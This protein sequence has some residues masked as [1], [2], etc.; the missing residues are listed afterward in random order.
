MTPISTRLCVTI[1]TLTVGACA[2]AQRVPDEVRSVRPFRTYAVGL[3]L[4][5]GG[6]GGELATPL[7]QHL[8][9][10]G[11]GQ[12]FHYSTS[13]TTNGLNATGQLELNN[14]YVAIGY[15]P[16]H[17][18]FHITPGVTFHNRNNVSAVLNE[19]AGSTFT[20]N[21]VDY[22]SQAND[23]IKGNASIVFGKMVAPRLTLG[24][25]NMFPSGGRRFSFP[26]EV[27]AEYA[28]AP[29]VT[30][31]FS[32]SACTNQGCGS[33]NTP[34]NRANIAGEQNKL[35]AD[36]LPLRFYPIVSFGITYRL[37]R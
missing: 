28:S 18:G 34:E 16:F 31:A 26:V 4:G 15:F 19:P 30:L 7:S 32:G 33:I 29:V 24:W 10:R 36:L 3:R 1:L 12:A 6:I 20:L 37:N 11:G 35:N 14:A 23:P 22:T 13:F 9:L 17:S 21:D 2:Y 5:S 8:D 25:G 27:G